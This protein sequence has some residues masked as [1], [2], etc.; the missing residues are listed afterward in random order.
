M[1]KQQFEKPFLLFEQ[2]MR[3]T[4]T[5][6]R[7]IFGTA[8]VP[9]HQ[10]PLYRLPRQHTVLQGQPGSTEEVQYKCSSD[11]ESLWREFGSRTASF[12][13][14]PCSGHMTCVCW[15]WSAVAGIV[16][17][18]CVAVGYIKLLQTSRFLCGSQLCRPAGAA[19]T[20]RSRQASIG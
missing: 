1:S 12:Y 8:L 6:N 15:S 3:D 19:R 20:E 9:V 7:E 5:K 14:N 17:E 18:H 11:S 2:N 4:T 13:E 16:M 10:R